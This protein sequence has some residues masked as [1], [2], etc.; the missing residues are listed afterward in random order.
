[1][2]KQTKTVLRKLPAAKLLVPDGNLVRVTI[3]LSKSSVEF[4][5]N[6]AKE[7]N[8]QYQKMIRNLLDIY[9][10]SQQPSLVA[11]TNGYTTAAIS[12]NKLTFESIL[13][14][15]FGN[16]LANRIIKLLQ[17]LRPNRQ[18]LKVSS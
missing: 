17:K 2:K 9:A 10:T 13:F 18:A 8:T 16:T 6:E 3:Y 4:F 11:S 1:M 5:K 14:F 15:V 7:N 12:R